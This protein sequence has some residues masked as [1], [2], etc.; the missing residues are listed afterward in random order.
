MKI[1]Q[2]RE[3]AT[4][5]KFRVGD[6]LSKLLSTNKR[7]K[8]L[9]SERAKVCQEVSSGCL[10]LVDRYI[11]LDEEIMEIETYYAYLLG[12]TDA[13]RFDRE[14]DLAGWATAMTSA[15]DS[16]GTELES[17][18]RISLPSPSPFRKHLR[19]KIS[20]VFAALLV[21][22]SLITGAC[23]PSL[24][25]IIK[26]DDT[27][28]RVTSGALE[29]PE[30]V[31]GSFRSLAEAMEH[32]GL[33]STAPT[34][35]PEGYAL[36]SVGANELDGYVSVYAWYESEID[37]QQGHGISVRVVIY[38]QPES[39]IEKYETEQ[40]GGNARFTNGIR[41]FTSQ[42]K[43]GLRAVWVNGSCLYSI[44]G[45][46]SDKDIEHMINSTKN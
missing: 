19:R 42:N 33:P 11:E 12:S 6:A 38:Q 17:D 30:G 32:Y 22:A 9:V 1:A 34:W 31:E 14:E 29:L 40:D 37:T 13:K 35:I 24:Y 44:T 20:V 27:V 46:I 43:Q 15:M 36:D 21:I 18:A 41:Y 26:E 10:E 23:I 28:T 2:S 39:M 25:R 4:N 8:R 3:L 5:V 16:F 45:P 7:Y